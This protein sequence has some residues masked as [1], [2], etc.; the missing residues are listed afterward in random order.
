MYRLLKTRPYTT[1][2]SFSR[3]NPSELSGKNPYHQEHLVNGCWTRGTSFKGIP[4]PLNGEEFLLVPLEKFENM[5]PLIEKIRQIPRH[6][7][8]NPIKNVERYRIY[9][10]VS[11]RLAE[12]LSTPEIFNHFVKLIQRVAPKSRKQA[13]GEV[14]ICRVFLQNFSGDS[15]RFLAKGHFVSGD[16]EGQQSQSY[17]FPYGF[18]FFQVPVF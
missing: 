18:F 13:E 15:I 6:G 17:R 5:S 2:S 16:H 9:G 12:A 11:R 1:V 10:E 8:H 4:D 7:L 3:L 14:E